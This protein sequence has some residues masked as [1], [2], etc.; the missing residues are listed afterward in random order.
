[1]CS[2]PNFP[3]ITSNWFAHVAKPNPG[4]HDVNVVVRLYRMCAV[5]VCLLETLLIK[6]H[7]YA[8][9]KMS[10]HFLCR[11][12]TVQTYWIK[13]QR[14]AINLRV[15]YFMVTLTMNFSWNWRNSY[16][17]GLFLH[18]ML[19]NITLLYWNSDWHWMGVAWQWHD[20]RHF[21]WMVQFS[22][23]QALWV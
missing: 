23:L 6:Y 16:F 12:H 19:V 1:M 15:S 17:A 3:G 7:L 4:L 18:V 14:K 10:H 13:G 21:H 9:L 8:N 5:Y 22:M 11:N 2:T 20:V